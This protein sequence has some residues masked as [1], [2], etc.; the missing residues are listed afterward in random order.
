MTPSKAWLILLFCAACTPATPVSP[1]LTGTPADHK[2]EATDHA[3]LPTRV[4]LEPA[5]LATVKLST[6]KVLRKSLPITLDIPGEVAA[7]PDRS[8]RIVARLPGLIASVH[9]KEGQS[10]KAGDLLAV[11][12][13]V[14]LLR[15]AATYRAAT[16]RQSAAAQ[17]ATR[18]Q[19]LSGSGL[20]AGQDLLD[21]QAQAASL[22]ADAQAARRTL[23]ALGIPDSQISAA[24]ARYELRAPIAGYAMSRS[25]IVGQSVAA[26]HVLCDIVDLSHAYFV[27]RLYEKNVARI[28]IGQPAE[29]RLHAYGDAVFVG[30][31]ET[32]SRQLDPSA[33]TVVTRILIPNH[34]DLLKIGLFGKARVSLGEPQAQAEGLVVPS[35]AVTRIAHKQVVFV[36]QSDGHFEVHPV[37]LGP[38]AS[39][40][41][42]VLSGL[43]LGEEVVTDGVF[44][45]RSL[46]LKSTFA[47]ED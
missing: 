28:H 3:P 43:S 30:A 47:E 2:D 44:T 27:G 7:D 18:L 23:N 22:S 34:D 35:A 4:S 33:R 41:V 5:V 36:R 10:V 15:T 24:T 8:R 31:V 1:A 21:A 32:V 46:V 25:A 9:F 39:G 6:N 40:E 19:A 17:N 14:D 42:V 16:A 38:S 11:L 29:V 37:T 26:D 13:S 20:A 45:L 12:E